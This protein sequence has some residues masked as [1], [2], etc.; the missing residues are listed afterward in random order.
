MLSVKPLV[1][2]INDHIQRETERKLQAGSDWRP[3]RAELFHGDQG[4]AF[5]LS[6]AVAAMAGAWMQGRG[7]TGANPYLPTIMKMIDD[8]VSDQVRKNSSGMQFLREQKGDLK[9]AALEMKQKQLRYAQQRLDG[10]ALRDSSD[11][12]RAGVEKTRQ[13]MIAQNAKWEQEKRQSIERTTSTNTTKTLSHSNATKPAAAVGERTPDQAKAQ[14]A[15]DAI[16]NFGNKAGL[17]RGPDGKWRV[18]GGAFPPAALEKLNPF[19]DD[20]IK[21]AAEAAVEA[22]GRLQSGGV[23]GAEERPAFQEQLGMNTLTRAQL[24]ARLN[25]AENALHAR[26]KSTDAT[27]LGADT[28]APAGWKK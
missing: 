14:G 4:V 8:N 15:F 5:G 21:S 13:E 16:G 22:Y 6:A 26:L 28:T 2:D 7:L 23:I 1:R 27:K 24:A 3:D 25:A 19:S 11:I 9:A 17:Q 12:M 10:L 20:S 18:G